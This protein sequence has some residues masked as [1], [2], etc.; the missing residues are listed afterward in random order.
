MQGQGRRTASRVESTALRKNAQY[1]TSL[2]LQ[3]LRIHLPM[4]REDRGLIPDPICGRAA[5]P[6]RHNY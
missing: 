5:K 4:Q 3:W 1:R 2:V 6:M